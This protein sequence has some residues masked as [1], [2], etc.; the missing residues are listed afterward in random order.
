MAENPNM[1]VEVDT[2]FLRAFN[3]DVR[4][5][6]G[7]GRVPLTKFYQAWKVIVAAEWSN[8]R[9]GGG[10]FRGVQAWDPLKDS[11]RPDQQ[12]AI[13]NQA[14]GQ[15]LATVLTDKAEVS[16]DTLTI[17]GKIAEYGKYAF[18]KG[19]RNPIFFKNPDDSDLLKRVADDYV[20]KTIKNAD[21]K[22]SR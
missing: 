14:S 18:D 22:R 5:A 16:A 12:D 21:K 1:S 2:R 7:N 15:L 19:G 8:M 3:E 13:I 9:R 17:G 11:T 10:S 20:T 6:L 4:K